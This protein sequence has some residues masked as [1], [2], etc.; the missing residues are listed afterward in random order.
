MGR[1]DNYIDPYAPARQRYLDD[2]V[3]YDPPAPIGY[4][5]KSFAVEGWGKQ[6]TFELE[7][8]DGDATLVVEKGEL[9]THKRIGIGHDRRYTD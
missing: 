6:I 2:Y 3:R 9:L 4:T 1:F 7:G 8:P 5:I